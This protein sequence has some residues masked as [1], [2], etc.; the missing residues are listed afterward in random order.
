MI[1]MDDGMMVAEAMP[2]M[3]GGPQ[4]AMAKSSP[5][6][7]SSTTGGTASAGGD[8]GAGGGGGGD[9][10]EV[11]L[12]EGFRCGA[13]PETG[14]NTLDSKAENCCR[15]RS[16]ADPKRVQYTNL[17]VRD[18]T[19]AVNLGESTQAG[20]TNL[21]NAGLSSNCPVI[22]PYITPMVHKN[23]RARQRLALSEPQ[24]HPDEHAIRD[25]SRRHD[26]HVQNVRFLPL[27]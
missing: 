19:A 16:G 12:R 5:P 4:M 9:G 21:G 25:H 18:V 22:S 10:G 8:S 20:C 14:W 27:K 7:T 26:H 3:D 13:T 15:K 2:A 11:S 17:E 23:S 1:A 6:A 24:R